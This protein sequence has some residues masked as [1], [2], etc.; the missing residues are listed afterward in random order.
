MDIFAIRSTAVARIPTLGMPIQFLTV[1]TRIKYDK[2]T[3]KPIEAH[4]LI[5]NKSSNETLKIKYKENYKLDTG[6]FKALVRDY[7][8]N[9]ILEDE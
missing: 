1:G 2:N 8:I 3:N 4:M 9:S 6:V 5:T 7:N